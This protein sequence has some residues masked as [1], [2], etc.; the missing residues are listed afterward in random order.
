MKRIKSG[1]FIVLLLVLGIAIGGCTAENKDAYN[2]NK[3][4]NAYIT[5]DINPSIEIITDDSGLVADVNGINDDGMKLLIDTD[6]T[7]KSVDVVLDAILQLA[8]E[9]G[10]LD[11]E[12]E[13]AILITTGAETI[14]DTERLEQ[15]VSSKV[16]EFI[17]ERQMHVEVLKASLE[18]T[19]GIK[20]VAAEYN[21][22]VGKVKII[23]RALAM[24]KEL[25]FAVAA[26]MHVSELNRIIREG[27]KELKDFY[28][29]DVKSEYKKAKEM[30][31]IEF[32]LQV[33]GLFNDAIQ[34]ADEA[35]FAEILEDSD[36]TTGELKA[37][38]LEYYNAILEV[39]IPED[40]EDVEDEQNDTNKEEYFALKA[41]LKDIDRNIKE[42]TKK[43]T[44]RRLD[45]ITNEEINE[46]LEELKALLLEKKEI[47]LELNNGNWHFDKFRW[48][49]RQN[50]NH[51]KNKIEDLEDYYEE[52]REYYE[53]LF[54]DLDI[55]LDDIEELFEDELKV[56]IEN[57]EQEMK[58]QL[59]KLHTQFK[60]DSKAIKEQ[61]REENKILRE[62]WKR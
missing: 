27:N 30:L 48:N 53:D 24:D 40:F 44:S 5:L 37:L 49:N 15:N 38:Y 50:K 56:E 35:V 60:V 18:A 57:L 34:A 62:I 33:L 41:R 8:V 25:T 55:D 6:F 17:E 29:E 16:T 21:I 12:L 52:V 13:N 3:V 36:L 45:N 61:I 14:E 20:E 2:L 4:T 51:W 11:F 54:D 42:L 43:I 23:T 19:E 47:N 32:D 22:S 28:S 59:L 58:S 31:E 46:V 7:G 1:L 9:H 39:E 10:Y 26:E